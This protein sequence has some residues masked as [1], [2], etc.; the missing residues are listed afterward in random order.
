MEYYEYH[1]GLA[2]VP[3]LLLLAVR[4]E[5]QRRIE[6]GGVPTRTRLGYEVWMGAAVILVID[7]H[8]LL[9]ACGWEIRRSRE[10]VGAWQLQDIDEDT[11]ARGRNFYGLMRVV[12]L[13][14]SWPETH[15]RAMLHGRINHGF[16]YLRDDKRRQPTSYFGETSGLGYAIALHPRR[17]RGQTLRLGVLGLGVGT[18]A[19]YAREGDAVEFYEINPLAIELAH[20]HFHYLGDAARRGATLSVHA[21]DA[22]L[23]LERQLAEGAARSFDVLA[24]DAFSGDAPPMHLLTREC[25]AVYLE[26]LAPGGVLAMNVSNRFVDLKPVVRGLAEDV[27]LRAVHFHDSSSRDAGTHTSDWMLVT[28][29]RLVLDSDEFMYRES[30]REGGGQAAR[31]PVLWTDDHSS[32]IG[33]ML[34]TR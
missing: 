16:Q 8:L 11:V 33:L 30:E 3:A 31:P 29:N 34:P 2:L 17:A 18:I 7:L 23:L 5:R 12:E 13:N 1:V 26:H 6:A 22:R 14:A 4:R 32:L 10:V 9:H 19:S 27:G 21:G 28:E 24:V 25:F 15:H 20:E